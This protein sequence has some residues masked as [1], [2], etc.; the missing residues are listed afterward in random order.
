MFFVQA[1]MKSLPCSTWLTQL[2]WY[3]NIISVKFVVQ[4]QQHNWIWLFP[5]VSP[6]L[7]IILLLFFTRMQ[8]HTTLANG[9][10]GAS[11]IQRALQVWN[12]LPQI[13]PVLAHISMAAVRAHLVLQTFYTWLRLVPMISLL[14]L[15]T[16]SDRGKISIWENRLTNT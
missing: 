7:H 3:R 2:T 11:Q 14:I 5:G 1:S 10:C 8:K 13:S 15:Q 6:P 16:L 9:S 4:H 12:N